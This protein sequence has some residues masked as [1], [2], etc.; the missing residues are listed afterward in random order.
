MGALVVLAT[1]TLPGAVRSVEYARRFVED[2]LGAGHPALESA[3][4]CTNELATNAVRH[5]RSGDG[6]HFTVVIAEG[7]R[8]I[9]LS[10]IDEGADGPGPR[11]R[12]GGLFEESGRG[13]FMVD[14]LSSSWAAE[15]DGGATTVWFRV[16][17]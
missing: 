4:I 10:V 7:R 17:Y 15:R 5:S 16:A 13:L 8:E 14:A 3:V 2:I 1:L 12:E 6:G 9:Q 11:L